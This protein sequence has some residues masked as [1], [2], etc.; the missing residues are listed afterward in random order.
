MKVRVTKLSDIEGVDYPGKGKYL[1]GT[2]SE[3]EGDK[4]PKVGEDFFLTGWMF[5]K[6]EEI[7]SPDTFRTDCCVY[8]WDVIMEYSKNQSS[9]LWRI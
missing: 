2:I 7:F 6:V 8:K 5:G 1:N 4:F 3:G 9:D